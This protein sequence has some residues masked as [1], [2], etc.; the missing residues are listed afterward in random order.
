M[1]ERCELWKWCVSKLVTT[2]V[3]YFCGWL[4]QTS[5]AVNLTLLSSVCWN[6]LNHM[7]SYDSVVVVAEAG[8]YSAAQLSPIS[9]R[10]SR[11]VSCHG[12]G[13]GE[14]GGNHSQKPTAATLTSVWSHK[15]ILT[16]WC[17]SQLLRIW[18]WE[19]TKLNLLIMKWVITTTLYIGNKPMWPLQYN[20][21]C[22]SFE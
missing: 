18:K 10:A 1:R 22:Q 8:V 19:E 4:Q 13:K 11:A 5:K 20:T 15:R 7:F 6:I 21:V 9:N 14:W 16:Y 2:E 12:K 3:V 17:E